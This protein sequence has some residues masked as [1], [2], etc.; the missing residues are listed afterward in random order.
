MRSSY[1]DRSRSRS[2]SVAGDEDEVLPIVEYEEEI[3]KNIREN[4]VVIITGETGSGKS[5]QIPQMLFKHGYHSF[6][7]ITN[8]FLKKGALAVSQ[9]RRVAATNLARRVSEE[10]KCTLGE[11]VGYTI[12]FVFIHILDS[13]HL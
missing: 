8:S 12:R 1:S 10:M 9:P 5:T 7:S 4:Q 6:R 11:E 3:L 2:Q 13:S